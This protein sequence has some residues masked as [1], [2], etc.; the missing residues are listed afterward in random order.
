MAFKILVVS[1]LHKRDIDFSTIKGYTKAIDAVQDDIINLVKQEGIT[2]IIQLGDWYDKGYRNVGRVKNDDN[3]DR[4]ISEIVNGNVFITLGNHI[5]IERDQN[6]E[7]YM[8]QPN[9]RFM[10]FQ[11]I[12]AEKPIFQ[13]VDSIRFGCIQISFFHFDKE[14]KYYYRQLDPTIRF[15]I[16]IYHDDSVVPSDVCRLA[17]FNHTTS[18]NYL[19]QIYANVDLA[20]VGHIHTKVG[21]T[22]LTLSNGKSV[23]VCI[24]GALC[25]VENKDAA[26]HKDVDL[27]II[28]IDDNEKVHLSFHKMSTHMEFLKFYTQNKES[29][30]VAGLP[31][32]TNIPAINVPQTGSLRDY[33]AHK[34]Y[35]NNYLSILEHA[36]N[37]TLDVYTTIQLLNKQEV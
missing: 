32:Q 17:G 14:N 28:T 18:Q 27:P 25:I 6:P 16:G 15:H 36:A 3:Y 24:P 10:P 20:I 29:K 9:K 4:K 31:E 33:L 1:D 13:A 30:A 5:Y 19:N 8:I 23:P 12:Y 7:M 21:M 34:G 22:T 11:P 37:G 2:H 26:K 35:G